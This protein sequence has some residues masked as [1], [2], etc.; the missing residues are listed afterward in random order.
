MGE[1]L[2]VVVSEN[3]ALHNWAHVVATG[4]MARRLC[5]DFEDGIDVEAIL[6]KMWGREQRD[7]IDDFYT[8][9]TGNQ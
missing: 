3:E 4:P 2:T 7:S 9:S 5:S 1:L 6:Q 8:Q